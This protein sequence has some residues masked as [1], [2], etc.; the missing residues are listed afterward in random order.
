MSDV[1]CL[2]SDFFIVVAVF[3]KESAFKIKLMSDVGCLIFLL[4]L[5]FSKNSQIFQIK[6]KTSTEKPFIEKTVSNQPSKKTV[7]N[8]QFDTWRLK[9]APKSDIQKSDIR[10]SFCCL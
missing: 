9:S 5:Q 10:H 6:D 1:G 8:H 4:Q 2:M 3:K 7:I